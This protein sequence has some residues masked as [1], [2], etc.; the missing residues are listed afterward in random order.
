[1]RYWKKTH[2]FGI[3]LPKSISEALKVNRDTGTTD[4]WRKAVD[5]EMKNVMPAFKFRDD[6]QVPVGF[7]HIDCHMMFDVKFDLTW[8]ARY[9]AGGHQMDTPKDMVHA[10]VIS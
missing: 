5:K 4:F 6:N 8:K 7:K 9:V 2:K 10:S 1:L 3:E